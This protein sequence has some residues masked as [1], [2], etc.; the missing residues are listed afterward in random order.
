MAEIGEY[1]EYDAL[2]LAALVKRREASPAELLD[3][4]LARVD[5]LNP[6]I[7]AVVHLAE[8]QARQAIERGLPDG[9]FTGV[10]FLLKDLGCEAIGYP[11]TS[12]SRFFADFR[13][14]YDS[15]IFTR[16]R[17]SGLVAFGRTTSPE[18]G[19]S[20]ATEARAYGGP[21]RN[22]WNLAHTSGGSSGGAG[23]A[24]AAGVVPMAHG[25]DGGGSV[26]IPASCCGL[27]GLK[28]TRAR[29]PDGPMAGEGWGGM[30]IDGVLTRSVRDCAAALDTTHGPDLGV[31][32][33]A[34]PVERPFLQEIERPPGRLR[35]AFC[36]TTFKGEPIH[37]E[38]AAAV[39]GAAKLCAELGHH[40]AEAAPR[41]EFDKAVRAWVNVVACGTALAVRLRSAALGRPPAD[42]E[43]EPATRGACRMAE[44]IAG[45]DYLQ[46][47]NTVHATG[48]QIARFFVDH[49]VLI[50]ALLAEPPALVGRFAMSNP[51][52]L[53]YRL[54]PKGIIHYS[55][56]APIFNIT[57][58]PA[59]SIPLHWSAD[60][61]PIGV[62]FAARF[63][64]EATL[65]RLA[66]QLE[67]AR[68]WFARRPHL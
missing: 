12:G 65:L 66:A 41:F 45:Q 29:L 57:G 27:F 51:D 19:I 4:A 5:R 56:F 53:D 30:S 68:P 33:V 3:A 59:A 14:D 26:R 60:G 11:T 9:P 62:Q 58:Q 32:Y 37:A 10:P 50:T 17:R 8:G 47:I 49:D 6:K 25:S 42:D 22:P 67:Q 2:G 64:E 36:R 46:S 18:L 63:G 48:R 28:P 15:E 34:P 35:I 55:P 21:T 7:N 20:P 40:V 23:A 52:F 43:I 1:G 44:G 31:P 61:L 24:V 39:D 13:W 38:C 16:H 54:G